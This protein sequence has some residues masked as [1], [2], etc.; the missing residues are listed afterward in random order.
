MRIALGLEYD[1]SR[2]CGWQTQPGGCGVQDALEA[3]LSTVH[4]SPVRATAA[5]RTDAGVHASA[6]VVHF[7]CAADRPLAAWVRGVNSNL[8]AG[9]ASLWATEVGAGFH[10]RFSATERGY[11]YILLNRPVRPA[12][13]AGRVGWFHVPLE[14]DCMGAAARL[15]L[16]PHDFSAFR[17]AECQA[18]SPERELRE[19]A[20]HR[21]GDFVVF[22]FRADAFLHHMVRNLVGSLVYVGCGRQPE[23]W[24]AHVLE[25]RDRREAAPTFPPDGLYLSHV[26]YDDAWRLPAFRTTDWLM[27]IE[28]ACVHE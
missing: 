14:A 6:Q 17:S 3:A 22:D 9:V 12:L 28:Q 1:G 8:P 13:L 19:A 25:G 24:I 2:F 27:P 5:G 20:V 10:A 18:K 21:R 23:A 15:L 26:R 11:R 7:D 16:G 4:G